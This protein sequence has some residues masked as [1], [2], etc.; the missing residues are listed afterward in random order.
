ML[1]APAPVGQNVV[2]F[3]GG[4]APGLGGMGM[5]PPMMLNP[6]YMQW[7]QLAQAW[8]AETEKRQ[9]QFQQACDFVKKDAQKRFKIDIEADSTIAPDQEAEKAARTQFLQAITPFLEAVL[10]LAQGNPVMGPL[11]KELVMF[12]VRGFSVSRSLEDAFETALDQMMK[13]PPQPPQPKG[14]TKSPQEVQSE[15]Q[16]AQG[17]QQTDLQVA[18]LRAKTDQQNNAVEMMKL[19]AQSQNDQQKL[20]QQSQFKQ[21]ELALQQRAGALREGLAAARMSHYAASDERG[22]V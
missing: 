13:G 1:G 18:A 12:A 17:E 4:G 19:F 11:V 8:Q 16:I 2:P 20:A 5:P 10:P 14:N 6:A 3:P 22:L 7:T 9:Q 15:Q 21:A